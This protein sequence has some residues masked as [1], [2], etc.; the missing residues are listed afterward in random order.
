MLLFRCG[1][2]HPH[3]C[4]H[5]R[6]HHNIKLIICHSLHKITNQLVL[7]CKDYLY[8]I[9]I[10]VDGMDEL[11][12]IV[13]DEISRGVDGSSATVDT[14]SKQ[15]KQHLENKLKGKVT[16]HSHSKDQ[17]PVLKEE[18]TLFGRS[19]PV[20]HAV[21]LS[22]RSALTYASWCVAG[23]MKSCLALLSCY[24]ECIHNVRDSLGIGSQHG[25][26]HFPSMS[27]LA[28]AESP[29]KG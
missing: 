28:A 5:Y 26:S 17:A 2:N 16:Q 22:H 18:T 15:M 3:H 10:N 1:M 14:L 20:C 23:R 11:W 27:S 21:I 6:H 24:R 13:G 12:R 9:T 19:Q 4:Y 8:D 7:A 25:M 29:M